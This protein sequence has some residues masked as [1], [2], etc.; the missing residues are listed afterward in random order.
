MND[1]VN[2]SRRRFLKSRHS[3]AAGLSSAAIF[4]RLA[5]RRK[6]ARP[7]RQHSRRNAFVRIGTDDFVTV[8][9]N[10][11]EM[12]QGTFT[13]LALLVAEEL[14]ADW[15]KVRA[16]H[17]AGRSRVQ[18]REIRNTDGRRQHEHVDRVRTAAEGRRNGAGH[19]GRGS[20][21]RMESTTGELQSREE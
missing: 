14:D 1:A 11:S 15:S 19:A 4:H 20:G 7:S 2:L 10:H 6:K 13:S 18:P 8:M 21:E 16:E 17:R 5:K 3:R 9:V 12:G